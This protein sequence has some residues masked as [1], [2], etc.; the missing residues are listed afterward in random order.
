ML[1]DIELNEKEKARLIHKHEVKSEEK[2]KY[3]VVGI[4][5]AIYVVVV[6]AKYV[7]CKSCAH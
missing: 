3:M 1:E 2:T 7:K 6:V 4:V 5:V